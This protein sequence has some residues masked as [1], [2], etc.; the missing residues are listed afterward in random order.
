MIVG[1]LRHGVAETAGPH[2]GW[3]DEPRALTEAGRRRMQAAATGMARLGLTFD[4]VATSP[5]V[6]CR[7]TAEIVCSE[8]G[9]T[10]T[11]DARLAPGLDADTLV[12]VLLER[13]IDASVLI[14]GHE[15]DLS[16][17]TGA[18]VGG[19]WLD[20]KKGALAIVELD[21]P[22]IRAGVLRALYPPSALRKLGR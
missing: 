15:P 14:C 19:G 6:R 18:L 1:L 20:F 13:P 16:T 12:D 2:T 3:R 8:I 10:P 4:A 21:V 17:V 22:R 5:L 7:Q 11:P 9:G